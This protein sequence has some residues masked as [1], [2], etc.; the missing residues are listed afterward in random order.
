MKLCFRIC[1]AFSKDELVAEP[2]DARIRAAQGWFGYGRWDAPY[3]FIGM[4]PGGEDD[5]AWYETWL[6]L[7]GTE[8]MDCRAHHIGTNYHKWHVAARPTHTANMAPPDPTSPRLPGQT[9]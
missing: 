9:R 4:E 2:P 7:G 1:A 8:L 3:W 5:L 6:R